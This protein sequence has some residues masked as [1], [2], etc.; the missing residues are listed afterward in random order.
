LTPHFL[1]PNDMTFKMTTKI[2]KFSSIE[3][4]IKTNIATEVTEQKEH[5]DATLIVYKPQKEGQFGMRG[6][7][8]GQK[9]GWYC[10]GDAKREADI[11]AM[12]ESVKLERVEGEDAG[13][14]KKAEK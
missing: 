10:W 2:P 6:I 11:R 12:C 8:I 3:Q 4:Y 13:E 14:E 5:G 1:G 9:L 7:V